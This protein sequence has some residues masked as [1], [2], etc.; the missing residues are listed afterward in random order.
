M[1]KCGLSGLNT[2]KTFNQNDS[3]LMWFNSKI[4]CDKKKSGHSLYEVWLQAHSSSY[5]M[6]KIGYFFVCLLWCVFCGLTRFN[7]S[8]TSFIPPSYCFPPPAP[9]P[10]PTPPASKCLTLL[11]FSSASGSRQVH[12]S[13]L[14]SAPNWMTCQ[15]INTTFSARLPRR[16]IDLS[17][18]G[19]THRKTHNVTFW[20]C[21][22]SA[23]DIIFNRWLN[24]E[25]THTLQCKVCVLV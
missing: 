15:Y 1:C 24:Q 8:S 13:W 10:P 18:C 4:T 12:S 5:K 11:L 6:S 23:A 9:P 14:Q 3:D 21:L 16:T 20:A 7:T 25:S 17:V 2:I 19:W 22:L